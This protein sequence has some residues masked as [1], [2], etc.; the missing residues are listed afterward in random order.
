MNFLNTS[1]EGLETHEA[2]MKDLDRFMPPVA[3]DTL[4]EAQDM[5]KA[6]QALCDTTK[7]SGE[8]QDFPG[9]MESMCDFKKAFKE[10]KRCHRHTSEGS[11]DSL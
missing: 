4:K 8:C 1:Q 2:E 11:K 5:V 7:E 3:L 10:K 6:K 9:L